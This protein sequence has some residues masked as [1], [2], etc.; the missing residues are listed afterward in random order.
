MDINDDGMINMADPIRELMFLF[1][2]GGIPPEPFNACGYDITPDDELR[3]P[4][5][6][7]CGS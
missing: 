6:P 4:S 1:A 3:C 5:F 2:L 7:P